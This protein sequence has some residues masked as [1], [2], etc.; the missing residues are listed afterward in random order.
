M[1]QSPIQ[2]SDIITTLVEDISLEQTLINTAGITSIFSGDILKINDEF[3]LAETVGV[4]TQE[5]L[6][7][8]RP[9]LG[10]VLGVHTTGDTIVFFKEENIIHFRVYN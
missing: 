7:V 5:K 4:G 10:S 1:M 6:R 9:W 3:M 8:R 2:R